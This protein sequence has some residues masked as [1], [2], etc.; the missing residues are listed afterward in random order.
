MHLKDLK[1]PYTYHFPRDA[2][3]MSLISFTVKIEPSSQCQLKSGNLGL[4]FTVSI[5]YYTVE[6]SPFAQCHYVY[7]SQRRVRI[8]ICLDREVINALLR[9]Q[10]VDEQLLWWV[11]PRANK[12]LRAL[13]F[14][15]SRLLIAVSVHLSTLKLG[16][17]RERKV[18][19]HIEYEQGVESRENIVY[20]HLSCPEGF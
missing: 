8:E 11:L 4:M 2:Q 1:C 6:I 19:E 15:V 16:G 14:L 5:I 9:R 20:S 7:R 17:H 12:S 3:G 13:V 10:L 18:W